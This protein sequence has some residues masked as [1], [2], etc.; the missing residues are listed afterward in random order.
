MRIGELSHRTGASRRSLRYYEE[1]G[2]LV[3]T[4]AASGQ[5]HYDEDHVRRVELVRA[6]LAAGLSSR[7]I[8]ELVPCMARPTVLG[9]RRAAATMDRERVR[10]SCAID[11]LAAARAVLEDLIETNRSFLADHADHPDHPV[12]D[13]PQRPAAL[14]PAR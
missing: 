3:S 8:A 14:H 7:A 11:T 9:A 1:Q 12:A 5:R 2:L 6:F 13:R 10:L 4:R